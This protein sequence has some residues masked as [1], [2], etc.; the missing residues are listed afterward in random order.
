MDVKSELDEEIEDAPTVEWVTQ[1][2]ETQ[3][4]VTQGRVTQGWARHKGGE[5]TRVGTNKVGQDARVGNTRV[6]NPPNG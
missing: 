2:R 5:D 4:R 3:A 1:G 6:G